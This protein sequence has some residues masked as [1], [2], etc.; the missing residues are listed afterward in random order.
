MLP[1][2]PFLN[3]VFIDVTLFFFI[4]INI[5]RK[6]MVQRQVIFS[7]TDGQI[8]VAMF[9]LPRTERKSPRDLISGNNC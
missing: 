3:G 2:I 5:Y 4:I 1:I 8:K 7:H 9:V 6:R